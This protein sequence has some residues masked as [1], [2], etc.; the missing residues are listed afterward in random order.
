MQQIVLPVPFLN[1]SGSP[2]ILNLFK[3]G[4]MKWNAIISRSQYEKALQREK[5]GSNGRQDPAGEDELRLLRMLI[6][7]YEE[8]QSE[9]QSA[10]FQLTK[11]L[12]GSRF[13]GFL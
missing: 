2:R 4:I 3:S 7:D 9:R 11:S 13:P 12:T 5:E 6:K 8:R 1:S 10:G